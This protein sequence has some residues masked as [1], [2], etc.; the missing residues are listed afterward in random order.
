MGH[1]VFPAAGTGAA[2]EGAPKPD[3]VLAG[4]PRFRTWNAYE[5]ADGRIYCGVWECTPGLWRISYEEWESC[6]VISGRSVVTPDG[7]DAI[8]LGP[9][10][11]L[12]LEPG[13]TGTWEV[14]ET[15]RK[16]YVVRF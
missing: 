5:S 1:I 3:R 11:S 9:G 8:V 12:V 2:E 15:T 10:D 7:G 13:F 4:Q 6:T 14:I 16:T